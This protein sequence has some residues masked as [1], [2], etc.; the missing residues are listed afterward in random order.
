MKKLEERK[1]FNATTCETCKHCI[2]IFR[3]YEAGACDEFFCVLDLSEEERE[4]L[5]KEL[6]SYYEYNPSDRFIQLMKLNNEDEDLLDSPRLVGTLMY[7]DCYEN[8]CE[9]EEE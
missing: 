4:A 2:P 8:D 3:E 7:C 1:I 9:E 5:R 6:D